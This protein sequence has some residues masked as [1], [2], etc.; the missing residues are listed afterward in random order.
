MLTSSSSHRSAELRVSLCPLPPNPS[1]PLPV[2]LLHEMRIVSSTEEGASA[3]QTLLKVIKNPVTQ[4][5]PIGTRKIG[6]SSKGKLHDLD[7]YIKNFPDAP[8]VFVIGAISKVAK[9][10]FHLI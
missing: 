5:F 8:T 1:H 3:G 10:K 6:T 9:T 7:E 2:Q 4:Y